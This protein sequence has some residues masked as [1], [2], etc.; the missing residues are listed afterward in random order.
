MNGWRRSFICRL[1]LLLSLLFLPLFCA[2]SGVASAPQPAPGWTYRVLAAGLPAV[3]NL[4]LGSDNSIYATLELVQGKLI[5]I[6]DG[7]TSELLTK[8]L[9]P[10][11]LV[12]NGS[13]LYLTEEVPFGRIIE[14]DLKSGQRR[15]LF[16]LAN[17]EGIDIDAN[18]ELIVSEDH[19]LGRLLRL[20]KGGKVATLAANLK[21]PEGLCTD[22]H[23][24]VFFAETGTGR[25]M[26]YKNGK[27]DI[28]IQGLH[29]PD[30]L[31][32][33][34]DGSVWITEDSRA[35]RLL[36]YHDGRLDVIASNLV[37]PQ[38]MVLLDNG[39]V[40]LA[41]QGRSRILVLQAAPTNTHRESAHKG[42]P[43][44]QG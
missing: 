13:K 39:S 7:K 5:R 8:L 18:D 10:D 35:G 40:L 17:P 33:D 19:R 22:R 15:T 32:C 20:G 29:E 28:I 37:Y 41:E 38:G 36:H 23:G 12:R 16:H 14:Y 43:A 27:I 42:Y 25:V 30:Q 24:S 6:V 9:R 1:I 44:R 26:R 31:E 21:R 34:A 4:A 11:G 3:D 2:V